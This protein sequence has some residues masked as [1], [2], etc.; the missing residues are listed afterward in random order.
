MKKKVLTTLIV[1]VAMAGLLLTA[2]VLVNYFNIVDVARS[3]HGG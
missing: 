3:I 2:H 1:L